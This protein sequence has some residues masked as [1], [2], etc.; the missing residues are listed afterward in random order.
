MNTFALRRI[1]NR[2]HIDCLVEWIADAEGLQAA[3]D[4]LGYSFGDAFFDKQSR[5][6][7]ANL[8]LIKPDCIDE[9]FNRAIEIGVFENDEWGLAA[10]L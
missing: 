1:D 5:T 10:K 3:F 7:A 6:G 2:A 4:F 9:A 8:P